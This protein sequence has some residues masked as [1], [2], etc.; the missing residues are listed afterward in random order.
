MNAQ[1]PTT[2]LQNLAK[3]F[4]SQHALQVRWSMQ[5]MPSAGFAPPAVTKA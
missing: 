1:T 5:R 3:A 4:A 2:P